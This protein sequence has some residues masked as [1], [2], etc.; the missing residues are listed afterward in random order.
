MHID[1]NLPWGTQLSYRPTDQGLRAVCCRCLNILIGSS[2][3]LE[4]EV[5]RSADHLFATA[6]CQR[7]EL[8]SRRLF[9]MC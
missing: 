5:V 3:V 7:M 2:A 9:F 4:G 6:R 1:C 8:S